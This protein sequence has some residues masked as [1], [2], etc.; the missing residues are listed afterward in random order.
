[1]SG[2]GMAKQQDMNLLKTR[3]AQEKRV[4]EKELLRERL[5]RMQVESRYR[6]EMKRLQEQIQQ[7]RDGGSP[8]PA[9]RD[10][11][12]GAMHGPSG[13]A[14]ASASGSAQKQPRMAA[15]AGAKLPPGGHTA[16]QQNG[17]QPEQTSSSQALPLDTHLLTI[18]RGMPGSGKSTLAHKLAK[19]QGANAVICSSQR[20][21]WTGYQVGRGTY[22]ENR[23]TVTFATKQCTE[24]VFKALQSKTQFV[25]VDRLNS[26]LSDYEELIRVGVKFGYKVVI[27]EFKSSPEYIKEFRGRS[28]RNLNDQQWQYLQDCWEYD[29]RAELIYPAFAKK[30]PAAGPPRDKMLF[31]GNNF[32]PIGSSIP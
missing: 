20:Y 22:I 19:R 10:A 14:P 24:D 15:P 30:Q 31:G 6:A 21:L 11:Q 5:K 8:A 27:I 4:L 12:H 29:P 2:A 9:A 3:E 16:Q 25:I 28:Q 18:I 1:M 7:Q 13:G 23:D 26:K 17:A 32:G